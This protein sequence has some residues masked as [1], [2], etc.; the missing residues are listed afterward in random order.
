MVKNLLKAFFLVSVL[1]C[2]CSAG[3]ASEYDV[4]VKS[5]TRSGGKTV[6]VLESKT[7][8]E[9]MAIA[10]EFLGDGTLAGA[11]IKADISLMAGAEETVEF[12]NP[13]AQYIYVWDKN[14]KPLCEGF[15][16]TEP[17]V[18]DAPQ[19]PSAGDGII[20]LMDTYIDATG[21][22]NVTV[23]NTIVTITAAGEY[24][25]DGTLAD[26]QIV[27]SDALS[28]SDEVVIN[29]NG[30]SVTSSDSA[31]FNGGGAK[32]ELNIIG[33]CSF[34]DTVKYTGY[35]TEKEPKG[36]LYSRRDLTVGGSG[37]LKVRANVKN[38]IVC[39]AD[40]KFKKSIN[41]DIAAKNHAIKGDNGVEFTSKAGT[42]IINADEGDGI[43]SDA[44]DSDT[45]LLETDKGYVTIEGGNIT[46][47][48][49]LGD[50][51]QADNYCEITGGTVN[52][53]SGTE[54]IKANEVNIPAS[55]DDV[56]LENT[57]ING[58]IKIMGG[59]VTI[60]SGEDGIKATK[61]VTISNDA[62]VTVT[63]NGV[64]ETDN[65]G[66]DAIQAGESEETVD[67]NTTK[68]TVIVSGTVNILGGTLNIL[69]ASDD[70][71]VA[72]GDLN[73][74]G[75]KIMGESACD[76]MKV[77]DNVNITGGEIDIIA[78]CDGIQSGKA[79]TV[80][81][82]DSTEE[83]SDYTIG[84][85]KISGGDINI[86][87]FEG[88]TITLADDAES[89]KGIKANTDLTITD[90]NITVD[91]SDDSLHSNYNIT[92]TGGN[93]NLASGDDGVHADYILT[94]GE[95]GGEDSSHMID[96]SHSY[97]GIEGS[98]IKIFSGTQYMYATDDGINAAGDYTEDG[99]LAQGDVAVMAGGNRPGFDNG[100]DQG[101][102][103]TSPYG[104]LYIK[105][106]KTYVEAYGDGMDS[107]GSIEMSDGVVIING[108]TNGGNGVFD[109]GDGNGC[110]FNVTGG[111][112]I[113]VGTSGMA[114]NPSVSGQG[115]VLSSGSS[116]GGSNRPG[117]SSTAS[118]SAGVA[119]KVTTDSKN[120]AFVPKVQWSYM[121]I[122]T[123]DMTSGKS[124][125]LTTN[126][127]YTGGTQILG[128][129]VN[130]IFYGL[131]ENCD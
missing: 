22:E 73:I 93:M 124:Y 19:N 88:H 54:G 101:A 42:V 24:T 28:K 64:D 94:L 38:G 1:F 45:G 125:S 53:T 112:L 12:L 63:A 25:I 105:G 41:L 103:E 55:E 83:K 43:K 61:A 46:I 40:L 111:T 109:N 89:S 10:V 72:K 49:P 127:S 70:A 122:T 91:S 78:G 3:Y 34:S 119:V 58:E 6:A 117:S 113:G 75:G 18:S 79:M 20:H 13:D 76:F 100:W 126:A 15:K 68:E 130:N 81:V 26:G 33:E 74:T 104:M 8:A 120:I 71:I 37:T 128:K 98:V 48:A 121:F 21:V 131:V 62:Q 11:E 57:F 67:G 52:I 110:Y 56:A 4:T 115:Y 66:Y 7:G 16:I 50:G 106:G 77:Y 129:T 87:T 27:V 35:T 123:P 86:Y 96:V 108:P 99:V 9:A 84:N 107:N 29:L 36:C 102:D 2:F 47:N 31:P 85:I 118:G 5:A 14:Q 39:G 116:G 17:E 51:I 65:S 32:L 114:V 80:T 69:G 44:I 23:D 30:V 60:V 97:E 90:G 59:S 82:T 95:E 92:I